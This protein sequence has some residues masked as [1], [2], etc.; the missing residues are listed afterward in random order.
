[1]HEFVMGIWAWLAANP[2]AAGGIGVVLLLMLWRQPGQTLK[3]LVGILVLVAL[4]YL[5]SGIIDFTMD[6]VT[7][8]E[9][10]IERSQ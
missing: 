9:S 6:S 3:L 5:V 2:L 1:M 7:V 10:G 8:K 4:G